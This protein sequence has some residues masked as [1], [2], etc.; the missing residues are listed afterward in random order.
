MPGLDRTGPEGQGPRTG[1]RLGRC[2]SGNK[3]E[4]MDFPERRGRGLRKFSN[5]RLR[6]GNAADNED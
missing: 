3:S 6:F 5:R 4:T 2:N 1:R